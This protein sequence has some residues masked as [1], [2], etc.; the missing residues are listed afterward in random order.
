MTF[1]KDCRRSDSTP[2]ETLLDIKSLEGVK[3]DQDKPRPELIAPEFIESLSLV[4]TYGA[5]KYADRN[6]EKGMNWSRP[7]GALMRHMWAW[8]RGE[9][10][11]P[12]TGFSHLAHAACCLMFLIT[13]ETRKPTFDDRPY[14]EKR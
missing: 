1:D 3:F 10:K 8:W 12:E 14:S 13:Y 6:W 7:F 2:I 4:L 5:K 9:D 11:D